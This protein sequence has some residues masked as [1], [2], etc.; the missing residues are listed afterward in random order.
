MMNLKVEKMSKNKEAN[1]IKPKRIHGKIFGNLFI[2]VT[3]RCNLKC[4]H[5]YLGSRLK[6]P[7][8]MSFEMVQYIL[9]YFATLGA[10]KVTFI[11]GEPTIYNDLLASIKYANDIGF[12]VII[13]TNG[14]FDPQLLESLAPM[15]IEYLSFSIDSS[16][17]DRH[18]LM[19][20]GFNSFSHI[21]NN[22]EKAKTL[23]IKVRI[24]ST[25]S[26]YN[27]GERWGIIKLA[28]DLGVDLL[29]IHLFTPIGYGAEKTEW[30]IPAEKW[31]EFGNELL[32]NR[33]EIG[34][35]VWFPKS[36]CYPEDIYKLYELGYQGCLGRF[37]D[38]VSIF[39][40]GKVYICSCL[41][42]TCYN[43]GYISLN[44]GL[45]LSTNP[46]NEMNLFL[47]IPPVC[48]NCEY[49]DFCKGGCLA[50]RVM[51]GGYKCNQKKQIIP[52]CRLWKVII[53]GSDS[54]KRGFYDGNI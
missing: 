44:Q 11:G 36:Y 37:V 14:V 47:Q 17:A 2:Y 22:I 26:G 52:L 49:L 31:I 41:F 7:E 25:L 16:T 23:G 19:R 51:S 42:D 9:D 46:Y 29:N 35:E 54:P 10:K 24:I 48:A 1:I 20:G 12:D 43:Y 3:T 15:K 33:K 13:D 8:D 32:E 45:R 34:T 38:R 50:E 18:N 39:P 53:K 21:V 30:I 27:Y 4:M 40:G 6:N 28:V 5:C